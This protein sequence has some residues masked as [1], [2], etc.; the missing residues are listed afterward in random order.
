M[1]NTGIRMEILGKKILGCQD[2]KLGCTALVV[3]VVVVDAAVVAALVKDKYNK[4]DIGL[5]QT[6]ET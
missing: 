3:V 6:S 1:G 2:S 5:F 4:Q